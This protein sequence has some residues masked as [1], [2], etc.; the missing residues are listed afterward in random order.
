REFT[1]PLTALSVLWF[2]APDQ[3]DDIE[4]LQRRLAT[5]KRSRDVVLLRNGDVVEGTLASLTE[6]VVQVEADGKEVELDRTKVAVIACNTELGRTPRPRNA[7]ARIVLANGGRLSLASA[8]ADGRTLTGTTVLG[9]TVR[10]PLQQL[11]AL[12]LRQGR[13]VYLSD[14]K[15]RRYEHV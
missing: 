13:A 3:A 11:I 1:V 10:V 14:L 4:M 2:A 7:Y 15:P 12:D 6:A 9:S 5:E 8:Q